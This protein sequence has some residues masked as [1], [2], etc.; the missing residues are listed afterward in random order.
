MIAATL[1]Q[2]TGLTEAVAKVAMRIARCGQCTAMWSTLAVLMLT[3]EADI[4][5]AVGLAI[6]AGYGANWVGLVLMLMQKIFDK[7]WRKI[8]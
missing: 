2:H 6:V 8:E 4:I 5:E 1:A 3:G 7:L